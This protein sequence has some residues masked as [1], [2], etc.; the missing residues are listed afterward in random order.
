MKRMISLFLIVLL[1]ASLLA[2]CK[3]KDDANTSDPVETKTEAGES[4]STEGSAASGDLAWGN[5]RPEGVPE[6]YPNKNVTYIYPFGAGGGMDAYVRLIFDKIAEKEGWKNKVVVEYREGGSGRVGW[7]ALAKAEADG[8][9]LGFTPTALL[10][11][12]NSEDVGFGL[13][14]YAFIHTLMADPGAIGVK[15]DSEYK[16]LKDLV[17]A[18]KEKPGTISIGVTSVIGQEGL[19]VKMLESASGAKFN[20]VPFNSEADV[21]AGVVGGHVDSYCLNVGDTTSFVENGQ[22]VILATGD[23]KEAVH[24]PGVPTYQEA[25]FDVTQLNIR[26]IAFPADTPEAI[27]EYWDRA[28]ALAVQEPDIMQ[29]VEE[30]QLPVVHDDGMAT[31]EAFTKVD[32]TYK[33]LWESDPWN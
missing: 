11:A 7:E 33:D 12:S 6:D 25:G 1:V 27:R 8:Y 23:T 21:F 2:G 15:T 32:Q 24:A 31:K 13:E 28:V 30:M 10:V 4:T 29:K 26:A 19:T 9:W 16:S 22:I 20:M 3:P 17:E 18:A 14:S 5:I